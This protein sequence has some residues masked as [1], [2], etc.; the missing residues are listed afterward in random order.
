MY[1]WRSVRAVIFAALVLVEPSTWICPACGSVAQGLRRRRG[2]GAQPGDITSVAKR[3]GTGDSACL[4]QCLLADLLLRRGGPHHTGLRYR[5]SERTA[6]HL[7][8]G[9]LARYHE[10]HK[11]LLIADPD[12]R[13][14]PL[15]W[16]T[17]APKRTRY[18]P[19]RAPSGS[20]DAMCVPALFAP[21]LKSLGLDPMRLRNMY[22]NA[23]GDSY[24]RSSAT[25]LTFLPPASSATA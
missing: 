11:A 18:L 1:S 7:K 2:I 13:P 5:G 8:P 17:Q 6:H 19:R 4:Y 15:I 12:N 24:P 9:R 22:V 25:E 14:E 3:S 16:W 10:T 21:W 23:L 20:P